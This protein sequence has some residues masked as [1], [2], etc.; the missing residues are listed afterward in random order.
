M[1]ATPFPLLVVDNMRE[2]F[3]DL[4]SYTSFVI[5]LVGGI[6]AGWKGVRAWRRKVRDDLVTAAKQAELLDTIVREFRPEQGPSMLDR[7][8]M[9]QDSVD[10]ISADAAGWFK[11]NETEHKHLHAR[12]D[13]FLE[14]LMGGGN[15]VRHSAP[16]R[17]ADKEGTEDDEPC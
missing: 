10:K 9:L 17:H 1:H 15:T 5:L 14:A 3:A 4:I 6:A 2:I 13:S 8:S 11:D 12:I 16:R 7:Q